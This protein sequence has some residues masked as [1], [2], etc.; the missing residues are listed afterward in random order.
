MIELKIIA[1]DNFDRESVADK[2]IAENVSEYWGKRIVDALNEK[3]HEDS[4]YYFK[5]VPDDYVL[6]RGMEE[7]V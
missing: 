1:V 6:W 3:L 5:L 2:L 7:L 4:L